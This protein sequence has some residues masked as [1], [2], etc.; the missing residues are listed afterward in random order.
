MAEQ[1][2]RFIRWTL[3][4]I[5]GILTATFKMTSGSEKIENFDLKTIFPEWEKMT[6]IQK[7][8]VL[9]GIK[10]KLEDTTAA[11]KSKALTALERW[12]LV[13]ECWKRVSVDGV[14]SLKAAPGERASIGK[15]NAELNAL[16][17]ES[18]AKLAE[19]PDAVKAV[20]KA[21]GII[22]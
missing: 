8:C 17:E 14:W 4:A 16:D 10:P 3:D 7:H 6:V 21:Q 12:K 9:T 11:D 15:L 18:K 1:K 5:T 19:L 20:L 13:T 22:I 2:Q